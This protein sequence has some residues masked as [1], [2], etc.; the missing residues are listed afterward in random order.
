MAE[1]S[2]RAPARIA[3]AGTVTINESFGVLISNFVFEGDPTDEEKRN[4]V[5]GWLR[6]KVREAW[7]ANLF[8]FAGR[9]TLDELDQRSEG[10]KQ[11]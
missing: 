10:K 4:L 6:E 11:S 7:K 8:N 9:N 5:T 3:L 1:E 2:G